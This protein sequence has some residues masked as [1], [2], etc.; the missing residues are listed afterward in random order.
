MELNFLGRGGA[1]N[2]KEGNNAA[3]F[4]ENNE[5]FLIDCGETVFER[6]NNGFLSG[7]D[8]INVMITHTHSDHVGS[9]GSLAMYSYFI[10]HKPL[11]IILPNNA[12]HLDNIDSIL[13]AF[14]CTEEMFDYVDER[15]LDNKYSTFNNVRYVETVHYP[16]LDSYS[17]LF[18][19]NDGV[20]YYSGD[21]KDTR[22]IKSLL[23]SGKVIDKIYVDTTTLNYPANVH[24]YIGFLNELIPNELRNR[25][26]CMHINND[27][28]IAQAKNY[29]FNVVEAGHPYV[30]KIKD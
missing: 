5:L 29:G 24:L 8:G 7:L 20:V 1:F 18:D 3:Y 13:F 14:G 23:E 6:L 30:K 22:I 12:K 25:V 27:D 16:E 9:L 2:T 26:Y 10:L 21:T 11:K 28:C 4:V 15:S 19:T 17:L